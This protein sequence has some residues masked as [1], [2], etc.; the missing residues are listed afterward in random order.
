MRKPP[1]DCRVSLMRTVGLRFPSNASGRRRVHSR[2]I[3]RTLAPDLRTC[4]VTKP[5]NRHSSVTSSRATTVSKM[6]S[7]LRSSYGLSAESVAALKQGWPFEEGGKGTA[8]R[9]ARQPSVPLPRQSQRLDEGRS[10]RALQLV[11]GAVRRVFVG[12]PPLEAGGVSEAVA[13][14]LVVADFDHQDRPD[15][16]EI[17]GLSRPSSGWRRRGGER[18][19]RSLRRQGRR[20]P[21]VETP[22]PPTARP[23]GPR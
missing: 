10:L 22:A 19:R 3:R 17:E 14:Q 6:S 4:M 5:M 8:K 15:G 23:P 20:A 7:A 2:L 1:S 16:E 13:G 12:A 18:A 9:A 11:H 21:T